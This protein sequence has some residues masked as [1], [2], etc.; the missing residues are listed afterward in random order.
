MKVKDLQEKLE[1]VDAKFK[2][3]KDRAFQAEKEKE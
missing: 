1:L 2:Q 3:F